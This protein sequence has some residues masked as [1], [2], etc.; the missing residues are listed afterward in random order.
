LTKTITVSINGDTAVEPN[1]TFTVGLSAPGGATIAKTSGAGTI[2]NDDVAPPPGGGG[3]GGGAFD[4]W[5]L[6]ALAMSLLA[7]LRVTGVAEKST[8][9]FSTVMKRPA[10]SNL[11]D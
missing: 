8:R 9:H 3:G 6:A 5:L 1:E 2:T 10:L 4:P 11:S 7:R